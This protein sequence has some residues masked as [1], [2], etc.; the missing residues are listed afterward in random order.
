MPKNNITLLTASEK[1]EAAKLDKQI[2]ASV[3]KSQQAT[4]L[5][6]Q[7]SHMHTQMQRAKLKQYET[8]NEDSNELKEHNNAQTS[9]ESPVQKRWWQW[10]KNS[11]G[12]STFWAMCPYI[13][14]VCSV[15]Q[16]DESVLPL[17]LPLIQQELNISF[18]QAQWLGTS[19]YL[20]TAATSIPFSK[21]TS[22]V[23][24]VTLTQIL[25]VITMVLYLISFFITN[26]IT[27]VI[28]RAFI[29]A[30][31]SGFLST[32]NMF[33]SSYPSDEK[34]EQSVANT[35]ILRM[36]Q[37][38]I[39]PFIGQL[40]IDAAGWQFFQICPAILCAISLIFSIPFSQLP[41]VGIW[42]NFDF[43]GSFS[44]AILLV[45]FT[46]LFTFLTLQQYIVSGVL[47][48]IFILGCVAFYYS[49]KRAKSPI[50]PLGLLKNPLVDVLLTNTLNFTN[51]ISL[52]FLIPQIMK[53]TGFPEAVI[54]AISSIG[55]AFGVASTF[56]NNFLA[57]KI[58]SRILIPSVYAILIVSMG[59]FAG[60]F[61]FKYGGL[62]MF[63][64]YIFFSIWVQ[65]HTF[66]LL[67]TCVPRS[68]SQYVCGFPPLSRTF[69]S[70]L[71]SS[72]NQSIFQVVS[73]II[74]DANKQFV[75]SVISVVSVQ[76]GLVFVSFF[77]SLYRYGNF[78]SE[79]SKMG[80][81]E[82]KLR[83]LKYVEQ[84]EA[85]QG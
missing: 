75:V 72:L 23:G 52:Q 14:L 78:D 57:K 19:Y 37:Q 18:S 45:G 51:T 74:Q 17:V 25:L 63:F 79:R 65:Q 60:V 2:E 55:S 12:S 20:G 3:S 33:V 15:N 56:A 13:F 61:Q 26:F 81:K 47:F 28:L 30:T 49:E 71:A 46:T 68:L 22:L 83:K 21:M 80:F 1:Q 9:D 64:V 29:G 58:V 6:I 70:S 40:I 16:F 50:M 36:V 35:L 44:L 8:P 73:G 4:I 84:F 11:P 62:V 41:R 48:V 10:T 27:L 59:V 76:M 66:A 24:V 31:S 43:L 67:L 34:R 7:I 5:D 38:V 85:G 53:F 32:R 42:S 54:G 77:I 82:H 39:Y 69:G